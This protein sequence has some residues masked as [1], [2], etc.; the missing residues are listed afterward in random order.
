[1]A[2]P[3][4]SFLSRAVRNFLFSGVGTIASLA[5]TFLFAGLTIR[6]LGIARAGFFMA[7]AALTGLEGFISDLGLGTPA[8]RRVAALNAAGELRT[9][10]TI[11]GS[12]STVT[13]GSALIVVLPII[14]FFPTIF[15]WSRLDAAYR[16]DAY[17]ATLF[18]LGS[19][20]MMK[21]FNTWRA[22]YSA[23]ERYGL[24]SVLDTVF[25]LLSGLSA[26]AVLMV[27]PTMTAVAGVRFI[28]LVLRLIPEVH[29][30]RKFLGGVPWPA[31]AWGELRPMMSF[32]GW[33]YFGV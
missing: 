9:A 19:F 26:I 23:L 12:V 7:L 31:W 33:V 22:T 24:I 32:G 5:I 6:Y 13:M 25:G 29:Y 14:V 21:I 27:Y 16:E 3:N 10:R 2:Q 17:W 11:V 28:V 18:T 15:G 20:V 30:I 1:M 8:V 4:Q